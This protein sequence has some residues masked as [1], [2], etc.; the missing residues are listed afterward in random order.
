MTQA[1]E[2]QLLV[3][4]AGRHTFALRT[5]R[6]LR[7]EIEKRAKLGVIWRFHRIYNDGLFCMV[8]YR[9]APEDKGLDTMLIKVVALGSDAA[10]N[11]WRSACNTR[12]LWDEWGA[13]DVGLYLLEGR[14][15]LIEVI[16]TDHTGATKVFSQDML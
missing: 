15:A 16:A 9:R 1:T 5:R 11:F 4:K 14:G 3:E 8:T 2:F 7:A 6:W 12:E 10:G 13:K